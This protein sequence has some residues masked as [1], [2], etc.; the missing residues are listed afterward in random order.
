ML[1]PSNE[2]ERGPLLFTRTVKGMYGGLRSLGHSKHYGRLILSPRFRM[3][4]R[5][6]LFTS[7]KNESRMVIHHYAIE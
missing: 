6:G 5:S 4:G 7:L 2:P 1:V 3:I